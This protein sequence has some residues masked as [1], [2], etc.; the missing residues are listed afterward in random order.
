[1]NM[2][3]STFMHGLKLAE[4]DMNRKMLADIAVTD[5]AAFTVLTEQAKVALENK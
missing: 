5:A 1:N 2:S 3:Y 4:I